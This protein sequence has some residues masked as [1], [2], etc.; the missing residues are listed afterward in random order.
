MKIT[1]NCRKK[2]KNSEAKQYPTRMVNFMKA[3]FKRSGTFRCISGSKI[4]FLKLKP[5]EFCNLKNKVLGFTRI[6]FN[7]ESD[8]ER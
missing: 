6:N 5:L 7:I 1:K 4:T 8:F 2:K 3:F